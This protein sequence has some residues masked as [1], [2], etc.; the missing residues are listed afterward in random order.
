MGAQMGKMTLS[1]RGMSVCETGAVGLCRKPVSVINHSSYGTRR[2]GTI[3]CV[4][5][6]Q[7]LF[8]VPC[9]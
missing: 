1:E 9:F 7:G 8:I 6:A 3:V 5:K 2:G 4:S